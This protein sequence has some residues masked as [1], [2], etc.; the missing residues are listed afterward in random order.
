MV[1]PMV[2]PKRS[3]KRGS[4]HLPT[5]DRQYSR[6]VALAIVL[7]L[8]FGFSW[9]IW[10]LARPLYWKLYADVIH[11]YTPDPTFGI[12]DAAAGRDA[13]TEVWRLLCVG[14]QVGLALPAAPA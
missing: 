10:V 14:S 12:G 6:F 8:L 2:R 7:L 4:E 3:S 11:R 9:T 5:P 13:A 1:V